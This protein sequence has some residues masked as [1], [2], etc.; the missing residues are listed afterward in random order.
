[1]ENF[2]V[3]EYNR[4]RDFGQKMN[5]TFAFIRQNFKSLCKSILF[6]A[7]PPVLVVSLLSGSFIGDIMSFSTQGAGNPGLLTSYMMSPSFWGQVALI[8]IFFI[9][10]GVMTLATINNYI[11]LYGEKRTNQIE[12]SEVW[13]RVRSTFWM[14]FASIFIFSLMLVLMY[15]VI[16]VFFVALATMSPILVFFGVIILIP[17]FLYIAISTSLTFIIRTYEPISVVNAMIR[18]V[19]LVSGKWWST[20]GLMMIL[21][22]IVGIISYIPLIPYYIMLVVSSMHSTDPATFGAPSASMQWLT[23]IFFTLYYLIYLLLGTLP[24]IGLAFQ[25][26]N[27]VERKEAKGLLSQIENFGQQESPGAGSPDEHY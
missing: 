10:S 15:I 4:I 12:V 19:K 18:S 1:M 5:A 23:T 21:Y 7:G 3:I 27:L 8:F 13:E 11:L 22:M 2:N 6:I 26:F 24:N 9:V 14:H 16:A 25:Y 20:F 17:G